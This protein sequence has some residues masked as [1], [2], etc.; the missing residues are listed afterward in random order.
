[1]FCSLFSADPLSNTQVEFAEV[2]S[3][4]GFCE[5]NGEK[6]SIKLVNNKTISEVKF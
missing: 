3:A 2:E 1:M 6:F 4:I 5:R